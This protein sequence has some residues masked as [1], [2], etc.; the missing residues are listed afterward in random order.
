MKNQKALYSETDLEMM[1]ATE[2]SLLMGKIGL[3]N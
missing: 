1:R 3:M 2:D